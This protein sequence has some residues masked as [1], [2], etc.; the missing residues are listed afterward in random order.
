MTF[1]YYLKAKYYTA[2]LGRFLTRDMLYE[3]QND[4]L[5]INQ[6]A[7]T[8]T[9]PVLYIDPSGH[10]TWTG[11][12][13]KVLQIIIDVAAAIWSGGVTVTGIKAIRKLL[14]IHRK[15]ITRIIERK[16]MKYVGSIA[17]AIASTVINIAFIVIS[18]SVGGIIV[19][20]IDNFIDPRFGFKKGNNRSFG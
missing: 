19:Y 10:F 16:I 15:N 5:S 3:L 17:G 11:I 9:N 2:I 12:P 13:N 6:Y 4:S 18:A 7:Y 8:K 14:K 20:V 1:L